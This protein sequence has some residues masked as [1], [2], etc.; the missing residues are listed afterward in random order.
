MIKFLIKGILR[1]KS[2]SLL[3]IIVVSLGVF[4]TVLGS[5]WMGGIFGD[6]VD[7]NAN[8][9]TGHVKVMTR[10]YAENENQLPN[11]LALLD[12]EELLTNLNSDYPDM[13][14]VKRIQFG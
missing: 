14:W 7:I 10:A 6:M 2:R 4:L 5:G 12:V 13:E 11:D 3:P 9:T 8:F 1:D